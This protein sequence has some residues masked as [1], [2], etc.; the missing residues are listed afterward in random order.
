MPSFVVRRRKTRFVA[1]KGLRTSS[2]ITSNHFLRHFLI[3]SKTFCNLIE[4]NVGHSWA[5][6]R[7]HFS[8]HISA[9]KINSINSLQRPT[10]KIKTSKNFDVVACRVIF[11]HFTLKLASN[12][13]QQ[14]KISLL[15]WTHPFR[16]TTCRLSAC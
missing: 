16:V 1:F 10:L 5:A 15:L 9:A 13:V 11:S 3:F 8:T 7:F 6:T 12:N 4:S 2:L 14:K